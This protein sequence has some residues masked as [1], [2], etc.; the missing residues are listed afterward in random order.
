[1]EETFKSIP[2]VGPRYDYSVLKLL[3]LEYL[4]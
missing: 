3:K 2:L 4:L 1:M